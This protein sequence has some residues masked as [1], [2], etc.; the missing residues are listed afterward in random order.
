MFLHNLEDPSNLRTFNFLFIFKWSVF[1]YVC[2][3]ECTGSRGQERTLDPLELTWVLGIEP[4]SS[5]ITTELSLQPQDFFSL[6]AFKPLL[7]L[8]KCFELVGAILVQLLNSVVRIYTLTP[9]Y[10]LIVCLYFS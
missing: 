1:V 9:A 7:I 10:R 6:H 8:F 5:A 2:T 3:C 4:G